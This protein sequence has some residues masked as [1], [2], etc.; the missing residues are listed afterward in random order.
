MFIFFNPNPTRIL[1]GDCVIRALSKLPSLKVCC[2]NEL[3][4]FWPKV[5]MFYISNA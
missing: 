3:I 1:V 4:L 2:P 5:L